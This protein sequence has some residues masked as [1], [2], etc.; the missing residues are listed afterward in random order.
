MI[1]KYM[2]IYKVLKIKVYFYIYRFLM[3][4]V[5][6]KVFFGIVWIWFLLRL[7]EIKWRRNRVKKLYFMFYLIKIRNRKLKIRLRK[8]ILYYIKKVK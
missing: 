7:L 3:L 2:I 4:I 8:S 1:L 6:R 5:L